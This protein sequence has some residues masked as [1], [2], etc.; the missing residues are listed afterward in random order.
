MNQLGGDYFFPD[1]KSG[2]QDKI[3]W[4]S[5]YGKYVL[6]KLF[7]PKLVK[8]RLVSELLV[9]GEGFNSKL[10]PLWEQIKSDGFDVSILYYAFDRWGLRKIPQEEQLAYAAHQPLKM[11]NEKAY[12]DL[13]DNTRRKEIAS[14]VQSWQKPFGLCQQIVSILDE[15]SSE[16]G[17]ML[18]KPVNPFETYGLR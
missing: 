4:V 16:N 6:L 10:S 13:F 18:P 8:L 3:D 14:L 7:P 12:L 11:M 9:S 1:K 5:K 2:L 17:I 15:F